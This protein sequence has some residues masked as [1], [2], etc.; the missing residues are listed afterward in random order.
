MVRVMAVA[1]GEF[2][3]PECRSV[4]EAPDLELEAR[5]LA[6]AYLGT[7]SFHSLARAGRVAERTPGSLARADA[8]FRWDPAPWCPNVL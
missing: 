5:D 7:A 8:M 3:P 2:S 4:H 1:F 6:A